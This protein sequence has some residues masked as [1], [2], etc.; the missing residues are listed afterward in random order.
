M[1]ERFGIIGLD[2]WNMRDFNG[3]IIVNIGKG[4]V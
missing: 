1:V 3:S 4:Q 2:F